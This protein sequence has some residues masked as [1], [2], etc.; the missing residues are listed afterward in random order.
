MGRSTKVPSSFLAIAFGI[1]VLA[2]LLA[3]T[4]LA[5][6][7]ELPTIDADNSPAT[8]TTGDP[9][10]FNV[11]VSD[12]DSVAKVWVEYW[13]GNSASHTTLDL[14]RTAGNDKTGMYGETMTMPDDTILLLWYFVHAEDASTNTNLTLVRSVVILDNDRP[15]LVDETNATGTTGDPIYFRVNV[16]DN[17]GIADV[18][19]EYWFEDDQAN[20]TN[21]SMGVKS[22]YG[23]GNGT[24]E[25]PGPVPSDFVGTVNYIVSCYDLLFNNVSSQDMMT[26]TDNDGPVIGPDTSDTAGTTGDGIHFVVHVGDNIVISSFCPAVILTSSNPEVNFINLFSTF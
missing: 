26:T 22:I 11:T 15:E 13:L 5:A 10:Y 6:D 17:I 16:T 12:N 25:F 19:V 3:G 21:T 9:Y 7:T 24:Y 20:S 14:Q 8:A 18:R 4:V 23:I 2:L 1:V